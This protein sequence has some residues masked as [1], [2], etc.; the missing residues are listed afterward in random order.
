[1]KRG[2]RNINRIEY[3]VV[4]VQSLGRFEAGTVVDPTVLA[5][6]GLVKKRNVPVKVLG[7]GELDRALTVKADRFSQSARGKIEAAGGKAEL[8]VRSVGGL[9]GLD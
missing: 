8:L 9:R 2:F 7:W 1:L 6:A 3:S 4:N 5:D